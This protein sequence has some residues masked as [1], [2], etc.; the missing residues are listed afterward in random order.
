MVR[1]SYGSPS[2]T[3]TS[4]KKEPQHG[5]R[6][7]VSQ[8]PDQPAMAD[9]SKTAPT[10]FASRAAAGRSAADSQRDP[11]CGPQRL[12]VADAAFPFPELEDG[13]RGLLEVAQRGDV[14]ADPC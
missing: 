8:R 7:A 2:R 12:P 1:K 5:M 13:L 9:Y 3:L 4:W 14:G 10:A 6:C 11:V